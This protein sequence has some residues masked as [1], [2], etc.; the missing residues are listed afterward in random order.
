MFRHLLV[1]LPPDDTRG[2]AV[3]GV[4]CELSTSTEEVLSVK[5]WVS[6]GKC[7]LY[8][9]RRKNVPHRDRIGF[10]RPGARPRPGG[11]GA[12]RDSPGD[13]RARFPHVRRT[14]SKPPRRRSTKA[15]R[16]TVPRRGCPSCAR[17]SRR[18]FRARAASRSGRSTSPWCPAASRSSS[19]RCSRCSSRRRGHLSRIPA[20]PIYE[21]MIRFCGATPVPLPLEESRGFSFDL[22]RFAEPAH[23]PHQDGDPQFAAESDRRRDSARR[24]QGDRRPAARSRRDRAERRDLFADLL[25][26]A[27]R[28]RSPSSRACWRRPSSSTASRRPTR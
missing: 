13:R 14:S 4:S 8:E 7:R 12:Q 25:R 15:G 17:P 26:R 9:A 3:S 18:T 5:L 1:Y 6:I 23:R 24:P 28:L 11:A 20:F 19:S 2:T 10:R 16:T 27:A 22:N 21:S